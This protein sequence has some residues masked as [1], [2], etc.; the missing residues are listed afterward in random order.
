MKRVQPNDGTKSLDL[1]DIIESLSSENVKALLVYEDGMPDSQASGVWPHVRD[2]TRLPARYYLLGQNDQPAVESKAI[3]KADTSAGRPEW[4]LPVELVE[5]IAENLGPDDIKSMRLVCRE[6]NHRVA[7]VVF[8]TV[9]VPFNTGI[10]G[11]LVSDEN[12]NPNINKLGYL[13]NN[14]N[15]DELYNGHC[16]DV[17][18]GFGKYIFRFGMSFELDEYAL[19]RAS[20]IDAPEKTVMKRHTSFWGDYDWPVEE[21]Q[22]FEDVAGLESAADETR[23]MRAAFSELSKVRELALSIDSGLGW[24]NGPDRSIRSII[25]Q[26][27]REVF[28]PTQETPGRRAQTQKELWEYIERSHD[29][30]TDI[31]KASLCRIQVNHP[32]SDLDGVLAKEQPKLPYLDPHVI[33]QAT[34]HNAVVPGRFNSSSSSNGS[35]ILY[36]SMTRPSKLAPPVIPKKL[37]KTQKELLLETEW[38]QQAFI[39]SYILAVI[40]NPVTFNLVT[41]FTISALSD[42]YLTILDRLDFW[43]TLPKLENVTLMVIPGFQSVRKDCTGLV[44]MSPIPPSSCMDSFRALLQ[45]IANRREIRRLTFG[46]ASGGEHAEGLHARDRLLLPSPL[47]SAGMATEQNK[48]ALHVSL[49]QFPHVEHLS[50]KNCW[51]TPSTLRCFVEIHDAF[52]LRHIEL[53]SVSLTATLGPVNHLAQNGMLNVPW[54]IH[55]PR[56]PIQSRLRPR[57]GSWTEILDI[58]SPG[59]NLAHFGN[60]HSQAN[61]NRNT[62]LQTIEIISCGY[63]RFPKFR[64]EQPGDEFGPVSFQDQWF[65]DRY[66]NLASA[67]LPTDD[68]RLGHIVQRL[69]SR[70]RVVLELVWSIRRNCWTD[71]EASAVEF[72]GLGRG[73]FSRISGIIRKTNRKAEKSGC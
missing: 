28:G 25:L 31:H 47:L 42:K 5:K 2:Q 6:L 33:H 30:N 64:I 9:V 15:N 32:V 3:P 49:L 71:E 36:S 70:E 10:Y 61:G 22:R 18:Q 55:P 67:M 11:M 7:Q 72:D 13:W 16:L 24:L 59:I 12:P 66:R 41:S 60:M 38:A 43:D 35:G 27:P 1:D 63:V 65:L 17:F 34:P 21:Y 20:L 54:S 48:T 68:A 73:G 19:E 8:K 56:P 46:W 29:A 50:L 62:S 44:T 23:R 53:N 45:T 57:S 26:K 37:T 51:V 52:D 4:K 39:N 58:I 14:S 69:D 40:D